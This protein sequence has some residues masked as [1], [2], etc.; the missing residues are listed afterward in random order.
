MKNSAYQ[1]I[2]KVLPLT[3]FKY[4]TFV[5]LGAVQAALSIVFAL[6]VKNLINSVEYQMGSDGILHS[7]L[8]LVG[9]V[10][11]TYALGVIVKIL[12]DNVVTQAEYLLKTTVTKNYLS[13]SYKNSS[14]ISS[15]DLLTRYEGDVSTVAGVRI[16]LLPNVVSTVVRLIGT[17][18]A[19]FILQPIF[20]LIVLAV[21][22][23]IVASSFVIR[24]VSYKLYKKERVENSKQNAY[25]SEVSTNLMAVKTFNAEECVSE[26]LSDKYSS[27]KKAR[28]K[29]RYFNSGVSSIINLCF[30]SFY[31]GAVI[32]GVY[33]IYKGVAGV[34]FGVITALLQLVLQIKTPI[35]GISGFFTAHAQMLV[36]GERLFSID[37]EENIKIALND[38]DKIYLSSVD[39][40]YGNGLIIKNADLEIKKGGKV[41]IKGGSGEGK[42][43]LIKLILGLYKPSSGKVAVSVGKGEYYPYEIKDFYS[44]VPQGNMLFSKTIKENVV[45]SEEY[46]QEK[47]DKAIEVAGLKE[48]IAEYGKDYYLGEGNS[49]SEGQ[50]QR[51]AVARAVYKNAPVI[52]LDEPTSA[53]DK[54]TELQLAKS[55]CA[56]DGV[57]LIII[58]HKPAIEEFVDRVITVD[59][60]RVI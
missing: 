52:I 29:H 25:L 7:S 56:L 34:D 44:F 15:G 22:L 53:L 45:F 39:F 55:L 1:K 26:E 41:L 51:I 3:N 16:N 42:S 57:T 35:T 19:M 9:V 48:V 59:G 5:G 36:A 43:T 38:F 28:R 47:F 30:T 14:R 17:V 40:S 27:Y 50:R 13:G 58:S 23:I 21:A 32:F 37:G 11:V 6:A 20:T 2:K 49:L 18:V 4:I 31:T 24:K 46:D 10:I 60:G 33:G 54:Q 12:G 8:I